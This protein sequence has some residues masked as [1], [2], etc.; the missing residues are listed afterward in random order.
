MANRC[1]CFALS[2]LA[3]RAVFVLIAAL[4][5]GC[6]GRFST[7][8]EYLAPDFTRE[9][10]RGRTVAVLPPLG[11]A[12]AYEAELAGVA[13]GL[14]EA[15]AKVRILPSHDAE[16]R[17][18]HAH[19][20]A[21]TAADETGNESLLDSTCGEEPIPPVLPEPSAIFDPHATYVLV[22][23]FTDASIYRAYRTPRDRGGG[24]R[25]A[26]V[27]R[28]SGR[29]IGLRFTLVRQS[30]GA[31]EW[32][33]A[34]SGDMWRQRTAAAPGVAP[35]ALTVDDDLGAGNLPLYPTP[36]SAKMVSK[37]LVRRFIAVLPSPP[38]LQ[39]N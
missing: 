2:R 36:P 6:T 32:V 5:A 39:P 10:L 23:H 26:A 4:S 38:T 37:R 20:S 12:A 28:T 16:V 17:L 27:S 21:Q 30:D 18:D 11:A 7:Q 19:G 8:T 14:Q 25:T 15:G 9:S 3:G 33:A 31:A 29:R 24:G 13:L 22:V 35:A 1:R 34:G